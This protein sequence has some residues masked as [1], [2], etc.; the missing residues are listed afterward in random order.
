MENTTENHD[1]VALNTP[2]EGNYY[3]LHQ[4]GNYSSSYKVGFQNP[5][6]LKAG[7]EVRMSL[8]RADYGS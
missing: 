5:S 8:W 3:A 2:I 7:Y 6:V 1:I 4:T